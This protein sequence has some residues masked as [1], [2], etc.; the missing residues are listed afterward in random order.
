MLFSGLNTVST[1]L[2]ASCILKGHATIWKGQLETIIII[3]T[4]ERGEDERDRSVTPCH[5]LP[6]FLN[7]GFHYSC[8]FTVSPKV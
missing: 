4:N 5:A 8:S 7:F 6:R 3:L 2:R 1:F